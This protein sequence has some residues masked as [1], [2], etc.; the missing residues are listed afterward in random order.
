MAEIKGLKLNEGRGNVQYG[1]DGS[2]LIIVVDLAGERVKAK[3]GN[4][5]VASGPVIADM[6]DAG[7]AH[8]WLNLNLPKPKKSALV[9]ENA[10]L[11]A[12]IAALEAKLN[13]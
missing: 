9:D 12:K 5:F 13:K 4:L 11:K 8:A 7:K 3:S 2:K 6:G 1:Q 10:E